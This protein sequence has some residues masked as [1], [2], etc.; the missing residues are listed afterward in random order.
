MGCH[1]EGTTGGHEVCRIVGLVRGQGASTAT[2][3]LTQ[4]RQRGFAF[5]MATG[6]S[7]M[8]TAHQATA[9][10]HQHM[11]HVTQLRA[12]VVA[13]SVQPGIRIA[14]RGVG[15][16]AALVPL[17]V[18]RGIARAG[19]RVVWRIVLGT[20]TLL[21]GPGLQQ[22]AVDREV[23]I[24]DQPLLLRQAYHLAQKLGGHGLGIEAVTILR[25]DR[26]IPHRIIN[27]QADE[28][29]EQQV[30]AQ[31]LRQHPLAAQRVEQLQQLRPHQLLGGDRGAACV[32][33]QGVEQG[34]HPLQSG[35]CQLADGAQ[36]VS[37]WH[38]VIELGDS[39][40]RF[41]CDIGATHGNRGSRKIGA[42]IVNLTRQSQTGR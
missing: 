30:V 34:A 21:R 8:S 31:L 35:V 24:R 9:V 11:P 22:C 3:Q 4:H 39:E 16:V 41:L 25:E 15:V 29:A 1:T 7:H 5:A 2:T 27:G 36:G 26:V 6:Q 38:E 14:G 12:G 19:A 18:R 40:Q 28:P 13:L 42:D 32:G 10:F 20:E 37:R 33:I 23:L 17:E